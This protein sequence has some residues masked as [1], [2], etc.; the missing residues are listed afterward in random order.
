LDALGAPEAAR[1]SAADS[2]V[3]LR[4]PVATADSLIGTDESTGSRRALSVE[5]IE[6]VELKHVD[7]KATAQAIGLGVLGGLVVIV[8]SCAATFCFD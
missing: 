5:S 7:R 6:S 2:T 8:L 1:I 4:E 3:V